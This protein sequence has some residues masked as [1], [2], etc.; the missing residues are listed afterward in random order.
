MKPDP[1][2]AE[3]VR[4]PRWLPGPPIWLAAYEDGKLYRR[5]FEATVYELRP[6]GVIEWIWVNEIVNSQFMAM[7]FAK[8]QEAMLQFSLPQGVRRAVKNRLR[9][10]TENEDD[11]EWL[12]EKKE[13]EIRPMINQAAIQSE[14][15]LSRRIEMDAIHR[16][17]VSAQRRRDL[18]LRQLDQRR[19][20]KQKEAA[21]ISRALMAKPKN[22]PGAIT[23][24]ERVPKK[25][26]A[27]AVPELNTAPE[28]LRNSRNGHG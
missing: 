22:G 8:W 24:V 28:E 4:R 20:R 27:D 16:R 13:S 10:G 1:A 15:F 3:V 26:G 11:L 9:H 12:A 19:S 5:L 14:T 17:E 18:S 21:Q 2:A 25:N 7:Q 6:K 23:E